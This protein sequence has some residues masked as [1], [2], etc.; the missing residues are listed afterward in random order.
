MAKAGGKQRTKAEK[1]RDQE[2][3]RLREEKTAEEKE[4][5]LNARG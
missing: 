1:R 5:V 3:D 2:R 4:A